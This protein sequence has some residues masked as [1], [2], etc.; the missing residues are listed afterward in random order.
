MEMEAI[1]R[2]SLVQGLTYVRCTAPTVVL[3]FLLTYDSVFTF[4]N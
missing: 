1:T 3:Q 2:G 4:I